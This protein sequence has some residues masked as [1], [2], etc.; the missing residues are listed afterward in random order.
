M[1]FK[2]ATIPGDGIG[3]DIVREGCRVLE[4]VGKKFGHSFTF[5]ETL[6]GGAAIAETGT[7]RPAETLVLC[8]KSDSVLLGAVG[9][10]K[11]DNLPGSKRPEAAL[12]GLRGEMKVYANLRPAL[13]FKQL[14]SACPLKA[15]IVEDGLDIL[16]VRGADRRHLLR[17]ARPERGRNY[18]LGYRKVFPR[19]NFPYREDRV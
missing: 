3:P 1:D 18:R 6:A 15:E 9:G 19:R 14:A 17:R 10:P 12:L 11:W 16:I 8:N 13:M 2:I 5:T 4:A 7:P